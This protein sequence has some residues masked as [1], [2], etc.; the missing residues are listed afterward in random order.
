MSKEKD[1]EIEGQSF[2]K[3]RNTIIITIRV[4]IALCVFGGFSFHLYLQCIKY[5]NDPSIAIRETSLQEAPFP[6][7]TYCYPTYFNHERLKTYKYEGRYH[8]LNDIFLKNLKNLWNFIF[9]DTMNET[10]FSLIQEK[11]YVKPSMSS[12]LPYMAMNKVGGAVQDNLMECRFNGTSCDFLNFTSFWD[13]KHGLCFHFTPQTNDTLPVGFR[14]GLSLISHYRFN[15]RV[16]I[17]EIYGTEKI[18]VHARKTYGPAEDI[19]ALGQ[20]GKLS[21][22][23]YEYVSE[24]KLNTPLIS[25]RARSTLTLCRWEVFKGFVCD[26]YKET[27][28][29]LQKLKLQNVLNDRCKC[30]S[31][32]WPIPSDLKTRKSCH[33]LPE[34]TF[35]SR[36]VQISASG[37]IQ[38]LLTNTSADPIALSDLINITETRARARCYAEF[39]KDLSQGKIATKV[40]RLCNTETYKLNIREENSPFYI[41][42]RID[43]EP[44]FLQSMKKK[45]VELVDKIKYYN[46]TENIFGTMFMMIRF[47]QLAFFAKHFYPVCLMVNIFSDVTSGRVLEDFFLY[48]L[49]YFIADMGGVIGLWV[50]V[51]VI[52]IF[53]MVEKLIMTLF[54]KCN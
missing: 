24:K 34:S 25:C 10:S 19:S 11:H 15:E 9:F 23:K 7:V 52:A 12:M 51:S 41:I 43:N 28:R 44:E 46:L 32:E 37:E 16:D 42:N 30:I 5:M 53:E 4:I 26:S 47:N 17:S 6:D 29:T 2:A 14:N 45:N 31:Y 39:Q 20:A 27:E 36:G 54:K 48:D 8:Y 33:F 40:E 49:L 13:G 38:I 1:E 21:N 35:L 50:G 3:N 18:F 22:I